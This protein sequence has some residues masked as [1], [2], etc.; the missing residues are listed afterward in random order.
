[1]KIDKEL[2]I[3]EAA[4]VTAIIGAPHLAHNLGDFGKAGEDAAGIAR[5]RDTCGGA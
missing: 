1:M 3:V 2:G 4:G 5:E